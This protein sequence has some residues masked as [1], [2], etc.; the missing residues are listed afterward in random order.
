MILRNNIPVN[1][2]ISQYKLNIYYVYLCL[3]FFTINVNNSYSQS[4]LPIAHFIY[5]SEFL[6]NN[7]NKNPICK[8]DTAIIIIEKTY[9]GWTFPVG[10]GCNGSNCKGIGGIYPFNLT[11]QG[12]GNCINREVVVLEVQGE[13]IISKNFDN[14]W[15]NGPM[16]NDPC[17]NHGRYILKVNPNQTTTYQLRLES[18]MTYMPHINTLGYEMSGEIYKSFG[19]ITIEV[20]DLKKPNILIEEVVHPIFNDS[21][22]IKLIVNG[23]DGNNKL[24]WLKSGGNGK[25]FIMNDPYDCKEYQVACTNGCDTTKSDIIVPSK[26]FHPTN[27]GYSQIFINHV[28]NQVA[29]AVSKGEKIYRSQYQCILGR[30][31][32]QIWSQKFIKYNFDYVASHLQCERSFEKKKNG[33]FTTIFTALGWY[34]LW[35]ELIPSF[36]GYSSQINSCADLITW[37]IDHENFLNNAVA[38]CF[39]D[40][41]NSSELDSWERFVVYSGKKSTLFT[42][43]QLR[44]YIIEGMRY[45]LN[46]PNVIIASKTDNLMENFVSP[47]IPTKQDIFINELENSSILKVKAIIDTT[48]F[49]KTKTTIQLKITKLLPNGS[50]I[51][52]TNAS[53]GT[54]YSVNLD[55]NLIEIS[56]NG[57]LTIKKE[58]TYLILTIDF[59][60]LL[61]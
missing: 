3:L 32:N 45:N 44:D 38:P 40:F 31:L 25:T 9:G 13:R 26:N 61:K 57:L 17:C 24:I 21:K 41:I 60:F 58:L 42:V 51:D 5:E 53:L 48:Y 49:L 30:S 20:I 18:K 29:K 37:K 46:C 14:F 6:F 39:D 4:N 34:H 10:F 59:L 50:V 54:T 55:S 16:V 28:N 56:L 47:P 33:S 43:R 12:I 2:C 22:T 8:G 19:T 36:Y 23:C 11:F 7:I 27:S 15:C 52:L 1:I 35:N